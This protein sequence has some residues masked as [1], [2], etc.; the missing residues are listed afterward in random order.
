[1]SYQC[2][3]RH[4]LWDSSWTSSY[5]GFVLWVTHHNLTARFAHTALA[6]RSN[7]RPRPPSFPWSPPVPARY[8]ARAAAGRA[9]GPS[10]DQFHSPRMR[11][12]DR[13]LRH[14][15]RAWSRTVFRTAP[16]H[17]VHLRRHIA[18]NDCCVLN[19]TSQACNFPV[20]SVHSTAPEAQM[21]LR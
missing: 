19:A 1:V 15:P 11:L 8:G 6:S 21:S 14:T 18:D 5:R 4:A 9:P 20:S 16:T 7:S 17:R 12:T 13:R 10:V 3:S 2:L